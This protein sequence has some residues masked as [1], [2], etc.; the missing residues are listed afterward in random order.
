MAAASDH[1][2]GDA[3]SAAEKLLYTPAEYLALERKAE[4]KSEYRDGFLYAMSGASREHNLIALNLGA[5]INRS[6]RDRPC[7]AYVGD[8]RVLVDATGLYT[9][10]DL[11]VVCDEPH[12]LDGEL[13]V[14]RNP[15][16]IVEILSQ[17]TEGYDR[18][19][20]FAH[21][22]RIGSLREYVLVAQDRVWVEQYTLEAG[23]WTLKESNRRDDLLR[24][25]SIGCDVAIRDVYAKVRVP[26]GD[27]GHDAD[28]VG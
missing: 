12:F 19:K 9:Y 22:R 27:P 18:G 26:E 5:E 11:V 25:T 15:T 14:L 6:L 3:M 13:D 20:K 24:L 2:G 1:F 28:R 16:L 8:M 23:K 21:Y 4:F 17:S 10:S 7:E